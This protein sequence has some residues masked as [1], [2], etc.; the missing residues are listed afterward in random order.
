MSISNGTLVKRGNKWSWKYRLDGEIRWESLKVESKRE[1]ELVRQQRIAQ[2]H[3][4]RQ[5]FIQEGLNP[6]IEEFEAEYFAWAETHKRPSTRSM[7]RQFWKQLVDFTG[8]RRLGDIN[9]RDIERLKSSLKWPGRKAS[10][11]PTE[12]SM[13]CFDTFK[14]CSTTPLPLVYSMAIIPSR[15]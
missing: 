5:E 1:A 8:A 9:K 2:Y 3:Q 6:T 4:D 15:V 7:E 13:R 12:A 10:P 14:A 11:S